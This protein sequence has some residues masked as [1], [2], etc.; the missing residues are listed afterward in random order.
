[1]HSFD[2]LEETYGENGAINL[3]SLARTKLILTTADIETAKR[4][5]DF[6]GSREVRQ[7]DEAY[8]YGYNNSRDASTITPRAAFAAAAGGNTQSARLRRSETALA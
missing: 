8:S 2:K 6:I 1:M 5:S 7:M 3:A 4:C